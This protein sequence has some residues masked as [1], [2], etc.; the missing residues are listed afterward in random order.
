MTINVAAIE[1]EEKRGSLEAIV[2]GDGTS[3]I[4]YLDSLRAPSLPLVQALAGELHDELG[5]ESQWHSKAAETALQK[6][7]RPDTLNKYP[8]FRLSHIRDYLRFRTFL[9]RGSDFEDVLAYFE[10]IQSEGR[11]SIVKID[12]GKLERPG[13]FG[14]RMI[15]TDLRIAATGMLVEHYM[16]FREMIE[17]NEAWLHKVYETWRSVSTDD[18]TIEELRALNRDSAFSRH[19]YRELL[20]DGI[21]REQPAG[22]TVAAQRNAAGQAILAALTSTLNLG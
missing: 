18:L 9:Y 22:S 19:A 8:W 21:L 15:A 16:T 13:S 6:C 14:W 17:V 10:R 11:V 20:F 1:T 4:S 2:N 7:T 3:T 5:L 12:T